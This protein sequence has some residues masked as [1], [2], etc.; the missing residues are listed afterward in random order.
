MKFIFTYDNTDL[1]NLGRI[2]ATNLK[3]VNEI[4]MLTVEGKRR[5]NLYDVALEIKKAT[6]G[7]EPCIILIDQY[8]KCADEGFE[9]LQRNSGIALIKFLRMMEVKSHIVLITPF[10]D[11]QLVKLNPTNLIVT[12]KGVSYKKYL[13]EFTD[14]SATDLATLASDTFDDKQDLKPYILAEFRLPEDERH[15]WANWWGIDRLWNVHRVVEQKKYGLT[16]RWHLKEYPD[17]LKDKLKSLQNQEALFLYGH[18]ENHIFTALS[19]LN[20]N[21]LRL[22]DSLERCLKGRNYY[23]EFQNKNQSSKEE[24]EALIK[25]LESQ[26]SLINRH[27]P[28]LNG[29]SET[30][31]SKLA[32]RMRKI[33]TLSAEIRELE[34]KL[35]EVNQVKR[36]LQNRI[37]DD[38]NRL[39]E[40]NESLAQAEEKYFS[41][42]KGDMEN[43]ENEIKELQSKILSLSIPALRNKLKEKSPKILYIDDQADEGWSNILRHI[44]YD[45]EEK[46]LFKVIQPKETDKINT[47]Y[48]TDV[49]CPEITSHKPDLIL[50][51]LRLNK[52]SGIRIEV[53]N[54]SGAILLKEIR[55]QFPGIPVLMTTA[56]NKSW[57]Y[58]EL[59]RIGCDAFWTKEGIDT[60][61]TE[62]DSVKNYIRFLELVN[63]LTDNEYGYLN[64]LSEKIEIIHIKATPWWWENSKYAFESKV[65]RNDVVGILNDTLFILRQYLRNAVINQYANNHQTNWLLPS[66]MIHNLGKIP[67]LIYNT[68]SIKYMY[69]ATAQELFFIRNC[70]S[71]IVQNEEKRTA[72]SFKLSDAID[73]CKR[74]SE[75]LSLKETPPIAEIKETSF[76]K[77]QL[78]KEEI[79]KNIEAT[80]K[81]KH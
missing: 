63:I 70:A 11:I 14:K 7:E 51:D 79:M 38:E 15:N 26:I 73:F 5:K 22:T 62:H 28:Y 40:L 36:R 25:S 41:S 69:D 76:E 48:F 39:K 72:K 23:L 10:T 12:S 37:S 77:L 65:A 74:I 78:T 20:E 75:Y 43:I 68:W 42:I 3:A 19:E 50:L 9:W 57:S 45:K 16:E 61:M 56:S 66:L 21:V 8:L 49:V 80:K 64:W 2:T 67:E 13:H 6:S 52:E 24:K 58:E 55:K 31:K 34:S 35:M 81:R 71:H 4:H 33:V 18:Q 59:Q 30:F 46:E 1:K 27:L 53:E 47:Q 54:L 29:R 17:P 60:G 32:E 44:I